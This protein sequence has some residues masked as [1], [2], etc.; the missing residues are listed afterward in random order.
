MSDDVKVVYL[1]DDDVVVTSLNSS[2][3]VTVHAVGINGAAIAQAAAATAVAAAA[4]AVA[5]AGVVDPESAVF[6]NIVQSFS[7]AEKLQGR[8]NI[9]LGELADAQLWVGQ[10]SI[11]PLAVSLSGDVTLSAAGGMAIGPNK[12]LNTMPR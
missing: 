4:E 11:D 3:T 8:E 10:S 6:T 9:G 12:V 2:I 5:A 7:V 1:N